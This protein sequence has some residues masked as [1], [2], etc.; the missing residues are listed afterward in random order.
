M[1]RLK[2]KYTL[3]IILLILLKFGITQN[4]DTNGGFENSPLTTCQLGPQVVASPNT[5]PSTI[6]GWY[7]S[8]LNLFSGTNNSPDYFN[9]CFIPP[10]L[11]PNTIFTVP[12]N[13]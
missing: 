12:A 4:I 10:L 5:F 1:I 9:S 2:T 13:T 7:G 8:T 11:G 6:T 3:S